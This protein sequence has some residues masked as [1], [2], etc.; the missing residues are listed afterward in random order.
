MGPDSPAPDA[1]PDPLAGDD[2]ATW[3][4]RVEA[5]GIPALLV[6]VGARLGPAL[7][8]EVSAEDVLQDA[9]LLA[10]RD[11][12]LCEWRGLRPFRR[13]LLTVVENHLRHLAAARATQLRGG[14]D[15]T[16]TFSALSRSVDPSADSDA[17]LASRIGLAASGTPSRVASRREEAAAMEEALA[18]LDD[19][20]REVVRLRLIEELEVE[21][22]AA[23][24]G[25]GVE[26]A[27]HRFRRGMEVYRLRVRRRL[28]DHS[29]GASS[30][31]SGDPAPR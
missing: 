4:R 3:E 20:V 19:D 8:R 23:R 27:R 29:A 18:S 6:A 30:S 17:G 21:Q 14:G 15:K 10:W 22:V 26:A 5:V 13:W 16:L 2:A 7:R 1:P 9:L 31:P 28:A 25:I 12:A 24:C 11:R